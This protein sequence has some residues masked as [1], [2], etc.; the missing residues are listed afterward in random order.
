[1]YC[2]WRGSPVFMVANSHPLRSLAWSQLPLCPLPSLHPQTREAWWLNVEAWWLN[3][4]APDCFPAVSGL[5]PESPQPTADCQ[6]P[7]GLPP[8]MA[9]SCRLSSVRGNRGESYANEPLGR[10]KHK[11]KNK[12]ASCQRNIY[13]YTDDINMPTASFGHKNYVICC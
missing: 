3:G 2:T 12:T 6:S 1:M 11:N 7:G 5:N 8:G 10:P 4:S 9:L 13:L